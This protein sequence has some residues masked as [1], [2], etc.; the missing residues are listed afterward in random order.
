MDQ[1]FP[2]FLLN[3][4]DDPHTYD[5][6]RDEQLPWYQ[7]PARTFGEAVETADVVRNLKTASWA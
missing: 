1:R 4:D 5:D 7:R 3:E 2:M 6:P